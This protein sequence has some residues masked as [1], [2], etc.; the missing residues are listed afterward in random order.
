MR[1]HSRRFSQ[2]M[3]HPLHHLQ[4]FDIPSKL[5]LCG[6][7]ERIPLLS[8]F[9]IE[10][11]ARSRA[12]QTEDGVKQRKASVDVYNMRNV[13]TGVHHTA[14]R[15][16]R[17]VQDSTGRHVHGG[18]VESPKPVRHHALSVRLGVRGQNGMLFR[19]ILEFVAEREHN[20]TYKS[21]RM[22][23]SHFTTTRKEESRKPL[24]NETWLI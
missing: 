23:T 8:G 12:S 14:R 19:R 7:S 15:A 10:Y 16:S 13:V 9:F 4:H 11:S 24:A 18:H 6:G 5:P 20:M 21:L 2:N 3:S 17:N 22:S 1:P